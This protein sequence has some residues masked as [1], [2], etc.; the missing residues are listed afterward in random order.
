MTDATPAFGEHYVDYE[1]PE[2]S[3]A[4]F[5]VRIQGD[6]M[7]PYIKDGSLVFVDRHQSLADGDVGLFYVDGDIKCRQ[8]CEDNYGNIYLFSLNRKRKDSDIRINA[9]SGR[10]VICFGK[11][12]LSERPPLPE[13]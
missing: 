9:T 4:D 5:A 3:R 13:D 2:N 1:V 6:S 8:Y 12:L 10:S 11:V 7:E